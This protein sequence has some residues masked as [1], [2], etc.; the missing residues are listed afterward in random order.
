MLME[1]K[2]R[3]LFHTTYKLFVASVALQETGTILLSISYLKYASDGMGFPRIHT[4]GR[5]LESSSETVYLLLLLLLAKGFTVTRGRLRL[6]SS[7]KLTIFMCV[8]VV[9]YS[10]LFIYEQSFFDP[11]KVLYLYESPAGY[12]LMFLRLIAW[13]MF[14]YSIVFTLKHYPEKAKFYYVFNIVGTL[15]FMAGPI[16][17]SIATNHIDKWVGVLEVVRGDA[18]PSG[19]FNHHMYAPERTRAAPIYRRPTL[20]EWVTD[21][22]IELFSVSRNI[23]TPTTVRIISMRVQ[24]GIPVKKTLHKGVVSTKQTPKNAQGMEGGQPLTSVVWVECREA[25]YACNVPLTVDHT[26]ADKLAQ[27]RNVVTWRALSQSQD[28]CLFGASCSDEVQL[29][30]TS[31]ALPEMLGQENQSNLRT[32]H[33]KLVRMRSTSRS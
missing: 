29:I 15:W 23:A 6:A 8:Y 16:F 24:S 2:S 33:H 10:T 5:M 18:E 19:D 11:G 4:F 20:G 1:L 7:V 3:Q 30:S 21:V 27:S 13:G 32:N 31:S 26:F 22:P 25:R 28:F 17:I 9:T 14:V 12:G